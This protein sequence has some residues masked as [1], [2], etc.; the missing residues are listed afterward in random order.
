MKPHV[1]ATAAFAV[2]SAPLIGGC[3][4]ASTADLRDRMVGMSETQLTGCMGQ[5]ARTENLGRSKLLTYYA[6]DLSSELP[7]L[8]SGTSIIPPHHQTVANIDGNACLITV[9]VESAKVMEVDYENTTSA[10]ADAEC[11]APIQRCSAVLPSTGE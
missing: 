10:Y 8:D 1:L 6:R 2:L 3:A 7:P 4:A 5:P 9:K 11:A